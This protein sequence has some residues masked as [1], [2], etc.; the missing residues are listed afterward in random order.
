MQQN[1]IKTVPHK[2]KLNIV[3]YNWTKTYQITFLVIFLLKVLLVSIRSYFRDTD[4]FKKLFCLGFIFYLK[5]E[6]NGVI[7]LLQFI[8]RHK[9][10]AVISETSL[11]ALNSI[12]PVL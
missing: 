4:F 10:F 11:S 12:D 1:F 5:N 6:P 2:I 8:F 3:W 9:S 7:K